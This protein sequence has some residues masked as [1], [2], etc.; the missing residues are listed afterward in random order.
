LVVN[1]HFS[2]DAVSQSSGFVPHASH[3]AFLVA[4]GAAAEHL[5]VSP[6]HVLPAGHSH[7]RGSIALVAGSL[8]L[9]S[10]AFTLQMSA[11]L[12]SLHLSALA[13][14]LVLSKSVPE[15]QERPPGQL[16]AVQGLH[17]SGLGPPLTSKETI[18]TARS[19]SSLG[20]ALPSSLEAVFALIFLPEQE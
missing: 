11:P 17:S 14:N 9:R 20:P 18:S 12:L 10:F 5:L 16:P 19:L 6:S 8:H 1:V 2:P 13:H 15:W 4:T 3:F 7:L